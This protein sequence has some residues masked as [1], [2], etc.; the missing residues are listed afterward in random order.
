MKNIKD[1][2]LRGISRCTIGGYFYGG[3]LD[4]ELVDVLV[5]EW[6]FL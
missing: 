5:E 2:V 1:K 6:G 4:A 3:F